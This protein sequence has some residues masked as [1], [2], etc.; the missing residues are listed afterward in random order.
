M[1]TNIK[2][3][4]IWGDSVAK[5]VIYDETREKYALAQAPAASIAAEKLGVEVINRSRMGATVADGERIMAQDLRRGL[6]ADMAIIAYGRNDCDFDWHAVS[7]ALVRCTNRRLPP[8]CL[9][10][11]FSAW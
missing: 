4:V 11:S 6:T 1:L 9:R 7:Q 5:G 8:H 2:K 3:V 10:R